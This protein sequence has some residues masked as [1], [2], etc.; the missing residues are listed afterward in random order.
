MLV[1]SPQR[2]RALRGRRYQIELSASEM[3]GGPTWYG[4]AVRTQ[5]MNS[6]RSVRV[7][8]GRSRS[9]LRLAYVRDDIEPVGYFI[10]QWCPPLPRYTILRCSGPFEAP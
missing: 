2:F 10:A 3:Y 6:W 4:P 9:E 5:E 7:R 1:R 8:R